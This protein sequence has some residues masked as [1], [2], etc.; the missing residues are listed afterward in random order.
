LDCLEIVENV[1][2]DLQGYLEV[3]AKVVEEGMGM[4]KVFGHA[5]GQDLEWKIGLSQTHCG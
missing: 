3:E 1:S 5:I 2:S 4:W